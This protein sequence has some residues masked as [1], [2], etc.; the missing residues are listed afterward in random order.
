MESLYPLLWQLHPTQ[1]N[2]WQQKQM[3][4]VLYLTYANPLRQLRQLQMGTRV[5]SIKRLFNLLHFPSPYLWPVNHCSRQTINATKTLFKQIKKRH[6]R[7]FFIN[8][9]PSWQDVFSH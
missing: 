7:L 1:I 5:E 8:R 4:L 3:V 2:L 6:Y 9:Q